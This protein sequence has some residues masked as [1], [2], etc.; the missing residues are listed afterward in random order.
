MAATAYEV[1]RSSA[2][3]QKDGSVE[4]QRTFRINTDTINIR[5]AWGIALI[6]IYKYD[7]HP[8]DSTC[9]AVSVTCQALDGELGWFDVTYTYTNRPFDAGTA[10]TT[11]GTGGG[12]GPGGNDPTVQPN[13][14]L[15]TPSVRWGSNKI[16]VPLQKDWNPT[17]GRQPVSNSARQPFEGF[18]VEMSTTVMTLMFNMPSS[19]NI[20]TKKRTYENTVNLAAFTPVPKY[21]AYQPGELRCNRWDGTLQFE[22]GYGWFIACEVEI[23]YKRDTWVREILDQGFYERVIKGGEYVNQKVID[24]TT[25]FPVDAPVKLNGLGEVL[26]PNDFPAPALPFVVENGGT[27]EVTVYKKL[28]P[29]QYVSWTNIYT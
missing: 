29:Y 24:K 8:D 28:Y 16:N 19:T 14:T 2:S 4:F 1:H 27:P 11:G 25:G 22:Q 26:K 21:G 10:N 7:A 5:A 13:P 9:L 17:E 6:N 12:T 15:R 20:A 18:E 3:V 23:E